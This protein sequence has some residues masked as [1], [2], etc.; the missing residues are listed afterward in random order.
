MKMYTKRFVYSSIFIFISYYGYIVYN[1]LNPRLSVFIVPEETWW[2]KS[3]V[4]NKVDDLNIY[5]FEIQVSKQVSSTM[6]S[7]IL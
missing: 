2:G 4:N 6:K 5:P 3:E 1:L 7:Q